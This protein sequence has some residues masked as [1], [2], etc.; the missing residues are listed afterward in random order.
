MKSWIPEEKT[1]T[2]REFRN[3][4]TVWI[5]TDPFE[6]RGRAAGLPDAMVAEKWLEL[7]LDESNP[8]SGRAPTRTETLV[9]SHPKIHIRRSLHGGWLG[10]LWRGY[11]AGLGRLEN[12]IELTARL[13]AAGAPVPE[14]AFVIAKRDGIS[15]RAAFC[16]VH[17]EDAVDAIRF[18]QSG[19]QNVTLQ[20]AAQAAGRAVANLHR[21]GLRHGDLHLGNL[22]IREQQHDCQA[23]VIDLDGSHLGPPLSA[24]E[25]RR[26][27][28][29]LCRSL[30]KRGLIDRCGPKAQSAFLKGYSAVCS[31]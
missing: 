26:Q 14:P 9:D 8:T 31:D 24:K 15:W 23:W 20:N 5:V 18:L 30:K 13:H 25:K 12:E 1:S 10:P 17:I 4:Q 2:L 21:L 6:A 16:T 3:R 19:P 29:R 22:L 11:R 28:N 27:L 7:S